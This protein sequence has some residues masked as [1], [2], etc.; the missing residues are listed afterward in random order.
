MKLTLLDDIFKRKTTFDS[1]LNVYRNG[2]DN[3]YPERIDRLINNSVTAK[4]ATNLMIQNII[5]KGFGLE[6]DALIVNKT[7]NTNLYNFA[8]DLAN[9]KVRQR[10]FFIHVM[11]NANYKIASVELLPFKDC[12][13]GKKDDKEYNGKILV[14]KKWD[15]SKQDDIQIL[16]VFNLDP[17]IINAQV[18][19]AGGW[20][21]YKGQILYVNDDSDYY[22]PLSRIDAVVMDC[23][24]EP[25]AGIYK[26]VSLR[27]GF[28]GKQM[29]ITRPLIDKDI[30]EFIEVDGA[31]E[32]N[33]EFREQESERQAFKKTIN[34]FVGAEN[35]GGALHV[36]LEW[37]YEKLDDAIKFV[38]IESKVDDKIFSHTENS[39]RKNILIAFNNLPIGLIEASDGIFSNSGEAIKQM[40]IQYWENC[41]KERKQ[42][43]MVLNDLF[44]SMEI[45]NG[46][47]IKVIPNVTNQISQPS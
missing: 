22:Y 10:G 36:E 9:S 33:R 35:A 13:I 34:D 27:K 29:V 5:G 21:S 30:E 25:Q 42:F 17:N 20:D 38:N 23:D 45:Y 2:E 47:P 41:E 8:D 11:P 7:K 44:K 6:H 1:K 43:E 46:Q 4:T 26:N 3:V 14:S 31:R 15:E 18:K 16:D 19:K 32:L 24:S 40:Q 28:F 39:V 12:R 37:E